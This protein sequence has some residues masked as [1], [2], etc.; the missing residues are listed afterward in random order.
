MKQYFS[1]FALLFITSLCL[2][3]DSRYSDDIK[4]NFLGVSVSYGI[5][6]T[7][8]DISDRFGRHSEAGIG[9]EYHIPKKDI[10][11]Y[12]EAKLL[13][14]DRV[15][16]QTVTNL[17]TETG[18][19]LGSDGR[20][21]NIFFRMRGHYIGLGVATTI[22]TDEVGKGL[23]LGAS[24]GLLSHFIRVQDD[25]NSLPQVSGDYGKG[26]DRLTRGPSL[27]QR[28]G[29]NYVN[30]ARKVFLSIA[31]E[32]TEAFTSGQRP[33]NFD[34]GTADNSSR[35]DILYGLNVKYTLPLRS[36]APAGEIYY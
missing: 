20:F 15:K 18:N 19:I 33:L 8:G 16:E 5:N 2:A 24:V 30:K 9:F 32:I 13:F 12:T 4:Y 17:L 28:I 7:A 29:Y 6:N 3:Q 25:S 10:I 31:L 22:L 26:Y 23:R 1:L 21:A 34:T 11:L 14:G 35:L 36:Y 27:K